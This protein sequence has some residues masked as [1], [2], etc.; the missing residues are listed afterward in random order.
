MQS[1]RKY[2]VRT[3]QN[4]TLNRCGPTQAMVRWH[5]NGTLNREGASKHLNDGTVEEILSEHAGVD[6]GRHE[7]D[8]DLWVGLDHISEDHDQEVSLHMQKRLFTSRK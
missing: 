5:Q 1:S 6:G 4:R 2:S 8:A 3:E 7:N